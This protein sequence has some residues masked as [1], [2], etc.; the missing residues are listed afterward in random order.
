MDPLI[1]ESLFG[2]D[3][4]Q[5][6]AKVVI[7][8]SKEWGAIS[9]EEKT[10]LTKILAAL[11][12]HLEA[13]HIITKEFIAI[14]TLPFQPDRIISFGVPFQPTV[15]AYEYTRAGNNHVIYA[16]SLDALDETKKR[17]LWLALKNMFSV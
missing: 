1:V 2:E 6:P 9:Q 12:I 13:V 7:G 5:I 15:K 17:N 16:D 3:L 14:D 11:K 10:Q 4:Y 8:I